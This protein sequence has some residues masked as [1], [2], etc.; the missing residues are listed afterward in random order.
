[1]DISFGR[2]YSIGQLFFTI[3]KSSQKTFWLSVFSK[4]VISLQYKEVTLETSQ[5]RQTEVEISLKSGS[6]L[7]KDSFGLWHHW[8]SLSA[9]AGTQL[10]CFFLW[11]VVSELPKPIQFHSLLYFASVIFIYSTSYISSNTCNSLFLG[12]E[13]LDLKGC[14]FYICIF[15]ILYIWHIVE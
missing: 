8:Y 9:L 4:A 5:T 13:P 11:E 7:S 3:N 15:N 10:K 12:S 2:A 14:G 6:K 1:M